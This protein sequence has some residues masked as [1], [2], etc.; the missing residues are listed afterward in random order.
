MM[1]VVTTTGEVMVATETATGEAEG[2]TTTEGA[3]GTTTDTTIAKEAGEDITTV[4]GDTTTVKAS[5]FFLEFF[6]GFSL[7][8]EFFHQK[9]LEFFK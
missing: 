3:G 1:V 9:L 7:S 2:V 6:S 5:Y 8:F 4:K